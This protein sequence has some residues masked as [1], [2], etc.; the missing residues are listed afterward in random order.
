MMSAAV[1]PSR[2]TRSTYVRLLIALL[3]G[4][5]LGLVLVIKPG[6]LIAASLAV[7]L[8]ALVL[9]LLVDAPMRQRLFSSGRI[10]P[11][12]RRVLIVIAFSLL[13]VLLVPVLGEGALEVIVLE[14][15]TLVALTVGRTSPIMA[16]GASVAAWAGFGGLVLFAAYHAAVTQ[17]GGDTGA[18]GF[19]F[20]ELLVLAGFP[21]SLLSG[22]LGHR[23][24]RWAFK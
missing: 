3:L 23:L 14:M 21:L 8:G 22:L 13:P 5:Q 7:L 6:W 10:A 2:M 19:I 12:L 15:T 17:P 24:H 9:S 11:A 16:I 18:F 20:A 4:A 1:T